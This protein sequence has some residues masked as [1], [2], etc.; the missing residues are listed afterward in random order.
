MPASLAGQRLSTPCLLG[1]D[2]FPS[3][4]ETFPSRVI[5]VDEQ[6]D[7]IPEVIGSRVLKSDPCVPTAI[8]VPLNGQD[9]VHSKVPMAG[10]RF[11]LRGELFGHGATSGEGWP[12]RA[13]QPD[14]PA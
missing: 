12:V 3:L 2:Q 6:A 9:E 10:D 11:R 7:D 5:P 1:F 13:Y 4:G 8:V 14:A